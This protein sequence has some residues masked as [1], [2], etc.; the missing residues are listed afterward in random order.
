MDALHL[1]PNTTVRTNIGVGI[2][3]QPNSMVMEDSKELEEVHEI[4]TNYIDLGESYNR[5]LHYRHL[6]ILKYCQK[7]RG[8]SST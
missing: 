5:R 7:P 4:S 3:E 8:R 2:S 6:L 1:E